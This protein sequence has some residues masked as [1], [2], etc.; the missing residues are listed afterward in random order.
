MQLYPDLSSIRVPFSTIF[1]GTTFCFHDPPVRAYKS[2]YC[3][4]R[5]HWCGL[6]DLR[7]SFSSWPAP[8]PKKWKYGSSLSRYLLCCDICPVPFLSFSPFLS[9]YI[10][11]LRI[12]TTSLRRDTLGRPLL[13]LPSLCPPSQNLSNSTPSYASLFHGS[14]LTDLPYLHRPY[15]LFACQVIDWLNE[16]SDCFLFS[17]VVLIDRLNVWMNEW[18]S[19]HEAIDPSRLFDQR[20]SPNSADSPIDRSSATTASLDNLEYDRW[21]IGH[22]CPIRHW[23]GYG[24]CIFIFTYSSLASSRV[25]SYGWDGSTVIARATISRNKYVASIIVLIVTTG[26]CPGVVRKDCSILWRRQQIGKA[27]FR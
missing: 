2:E 11:S 7:H 26:K 20:K 4:L 19:M 17:R 16:W 21:R 1:S 22:I 18:P 24:Q 25:H 15:L 5:Q 6:Q 8:V 12:K 13:R 9:R 10:E 27:F 3:K 23:S 14:T